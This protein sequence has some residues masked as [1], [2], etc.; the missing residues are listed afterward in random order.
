MTKARCSTLLILILC[1]LALPAS[2][3][4][5]A[6]DLN[7]PPAVNQPLDFERTGGAVGPAFRVS[8]RAPKTELQVEGEL[9]LTV[10]IEA[11]GRAGRPPKRPQLWDLKPFQALEKKGWLKIERPEK[12]ADDVRRPAA[13]TWEFDYTVKVLSESLKRIPTFAFI[14]YKPPPSELLPGQFP[15][16]YPEEIPLKV[17]AKPA[18][19]PVPPPPVKAPE[20]IFELT[21]S[22]RVLERHGVARF[23]GAAL[24][25]AALLVPPLLG[26]GWYLLWRRFHPDAARRAR[27]RQ[28]LA[29]RQALQ[30]LNALGPAEADQRVY[31]VARI[32]GGY[33][34]QR[35][36]LPTAE[37]TPAEVITCLGRAGAPDVLAGKA[38]EFFRACDAARFAP[39]QPTDAAD[40]TAAAHRLILT[41]EAEAWVDG[42]QN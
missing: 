42:S 22:A 36:G 14:Y 26:A 39:A 15:T 38:A 2:G 11:V 20:M 24:V 5:E 27:I 28:S 25:V 33:L 7:E 8:M 16:T 4:G 32:A 23:A 17:K 37:P 9:T 13:Q 30:A 21:E 31:R 10:R 29:A 40:L 12:K 34:Q 1:L 41:L 19:P 3:R 35:L 6:I 18:P